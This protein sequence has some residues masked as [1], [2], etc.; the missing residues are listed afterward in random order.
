M[1]L[2][3]ALL[4]LPLPLVLQVDSYWA[5]AAIL[6]LAL[7]GHQSFSTNLFALITDVADGDRIGRVTGFAAF[8]GNIGGTVVAKVAGVVLAAGL[9]YLPLLIVC[10]VSYLLAVG[11]LQLMLPVIRARGDVP[12][13]EAAV[14][15]AHF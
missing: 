9:G 6:A 12:P 1:L 10:A 11:V 5:A 2:G 4:V 15:G 3:S 8:C 14:A 7:A 13:A